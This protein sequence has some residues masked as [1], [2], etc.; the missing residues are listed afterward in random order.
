ML[1]IADAYII[2]TFID[3]DCAN[4]AH[5]QR[6]ERVFFRLLLERYALF[7]VIL[8]PQTTAYDR[9]RFQSDL[10]DVLLSGADNQIF[11]STTSFARDQMLVFAQQ[12]AVFIESAQGHSDYHIMREALGT[13][14]PELQGVHSFSSEVS[15]H[16]E[17]PYAV[18]FQGFAM[19]DPVHQA[20]VVLALLMCFARADP[21]CLQSF[22]RFRRPM[23][24]LRHWN[25]GHH[26]MSLLDICN[27]R[28]DRLH[29][30]VNFDG[31]LISP[32]R[33]QLLNIVL[34][35]DVF[36]DM[37]VGRRD[38]MPPF[39][40][41]NED[42]VRYI[43]KTRSKF[44]DERTELLRYIRGAVT[45]QDARS[46]LDKASSC[47]SLT[48]SN[49][50][51]FALRSQASA[52]PAHPDSYDYV[53]PLVIKQAARLL[54]NRRSTVHSLSVNPVMHDQLSRIRSL[55]PESSEFQSGTTFALKCQA[56]ILAVASVVQEGLQ[57]T[58]TTAIQQN[59]SAE[60]GDH[61]RLFLDWPAWTPTFQAM[62]LYHARNI[63]TFAPLHALSRHANLPQ[64]TPQHTQA[65]DPV[66][67]QELAM[68]HPSHAI[69]EEWQH[70]QL[71]HL[72]QQDLVDLETHRH[73]TSP[74]HLPGLTN[75]YANVSPR[76]EPHHENPH[77]SPSRRSDS[78]SPSRAYPDHVSMFN[79]VPLSRRQK[80]ASLIWTR[81]T[82]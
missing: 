13:L 41:L 79:L 27:I 10:D 78:H 77:S 82:A 11:F 38:H 24:S 50:Q 71:D 59:I 1:S 28:Q 49:P 54:D 5:V 14:L 29:I 31:E 55:L 45:D 9:V 40:H 4:P 17:D 33:S 76:Q 61:H 60:H 44:S 30:S 70:H 66:L 8:S 73:P 65:L 81:E 64:G 63:D 37:L 46:A 23:S 12:A 2:R 15:H 43:K 21:Q 74:R 19:D 52:E 67:Q 36:F 32:S 22:Q 3:L 18:L 34:L 48:I 72:E 69:L 42:S 7:G 75:E 39:F 47:E 26:F 51:L 62:S 25:L 58:F 6:I 20:K 16:L 53:V 57:H 80:A 68:L 56:L 35:I